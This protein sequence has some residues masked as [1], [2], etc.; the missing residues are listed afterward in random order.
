MSGSNG[1]MRSAIKACTSATC[2]RRDGQHVMGSFTAGRPVRWS[3][4]GVAPEVGPMWPIPA[5]VARRVICV[6]GTRVS[7][8]T[9]RLVCPTPHPPRNLVLNGSPDAHMGRGSFV[10]VLR[11]IKS[12]CV[13]RW[14]QLQRWACGGD[15]DFCQL[16]LNTCYF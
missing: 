2:D 15:A 4:D 5:H 6:L 9:E 14:M 7:W 1:V 11:G 3:V 16:T 12:G 10:V 8:G 13:Q